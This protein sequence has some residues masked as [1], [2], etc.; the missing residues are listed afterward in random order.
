MRLRSFWK[1]GE[2]WIIL[3]LSL[4]SGLTTSYFFLDTG[5]LTHDTQH[6]YHFFHD[7]LHSLN[8]YGEPAWWFPLDQF[9]FPG[10]F[11]GILGVP[12]QAGPA[13]VLLGFS[14]W[15]LGVIGV[16]INTFQPLYV[17]YFGW[18]IPLLFLLSISYTFSLFLQSRA[19]RIFGLILASLCPGVLL[20]ITDPGFLE[21]IAYSI[22]FFGALVRYVRMPNTAN[23]L[24]TC[25]SICLTLTVFN[26]CALLW[27]VFFIPFSILYVLSSPGNGNGLKVLLVHK[28]HLFGFLICAAVCAAPVLLT[29]SQQGD[30]VRQGLDGMTYSDYQ[31]GGNYFQLL[32]ISAPYLGVG[33]LKIADGTWLL[34]KLIDYREDGAYWFRYN[35]MGLLALPLVC[36][37][38]VCGARKIGWVGW[39]FIVFIFFIVWRVDDSSVFFVL[40]QTLKPLQSMSHYGD[41]L[42]RGGGYVIFLGFAAYGFD[43]FVKNMKKY[44]LYLGHLV[45]VL[46]V[47]T[48][49]VTYYM[50]DKVFGGST[51]IITSALSVG[52]ALTFYMM[53]NRGSRV[54]RNSGAFVLCMLAF[55]DLTWGAHHFLRS[56]P[57]IH[58][59]PSDGSSIDRLGKYGLSVANP[60]AKAYINGYR[61]LES[62]GLRTLF[63]LG[64]VSSNIPRAKVFKRV[65]VKEKLEEAD[66]YSAFDAK[67]TPNLLTILPAQGRDPALSRGVLL[68]DPKPSDANLTGV[69]QIKNLRHTYNEQHWEIDSKGAGFL[70]LSDTYSPFWFASINGKSVDVHRALGYFV[71]IPIESGVSMVRMVYRPHLIAPT[72]FIAYGLITLLFLSLLI[73]RR[74]KD[75]LPQML[76]SLSGRSRGEMSRI[77]RGQGSS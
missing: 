58:A 14:V 1:D 12:N 23:F 41:L 18:L 61:L 71:A 2:N 35:Y 63:D 53:H 37:G 11:Y 36:L 24:L 32:T 59:G 4:T 67:L 69:D 27:N 6:F 44:S 55:V 54:L 73:I 74:R 46:S 51:L 64:M 22:F 66:L 15:V 31:S 48:V 17:I 75:I 47:T 65:V 8:K 5:Q 25:L 29:Y 26:Y 56:L 39:T 77:R 62:K 28:N 20:N 16:V 60:S 3:L 57:Y 7:T 50:T 76:P 49:G 70:F 34:G 43:V 33:Q 30:L 10:Y 40:R 19:A 45:I 52:F 21:P 9:G 38:L 72:L 42:F 68:E 13:F